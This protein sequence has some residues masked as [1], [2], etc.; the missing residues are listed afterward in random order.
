MENFLALH[1]LKYELQ[2]VEHIVHNVL[3]VF[4]SSPEP[5]AAFIAGFK[6]DL[7]GASAKSKAGIKHDVVSLKKPRDRKVYVEL[8][9]AA[10]I[11]LAIR[12][13]DYAEA[14][15]LIAVRPPLHGTDLLSYLVFQEIEQLLAFLETYFGPYFNLD[16]WIPGDYQRIMCCEIGTGIHS[17]HDG[18][19]SLGAGT[20][21]LAITMLPFA[22]FLEVE[23][24]DT[25]HRQVKNLR[26]LKERLFYLSQ[27]GGNEKIDDSLRGLLHSI[28]FNSADFYDY[29][30]R[31]VSQRVARCKD[32]REEKITVLTAYKRQ[33]HQV[34]P[35]IGFKF[36]IDRLSL[37]DE[38]SAWIQWEIDC[39][40][41][42]RP[43]L[44]EVY[45]ETPSEVDLE[46][47]GRV[48]WDMSSN[49]LAYLIHIF[50][51]VDV[52][53]EKDKKTLIQIIARHFQTNRSEQININS[54][55]K[56]I[57][58]KHVGARRKVI[59]LLARMR[60]YAERDNGEFDEP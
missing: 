53:P 3:P 33:I 4:K 10:L 40:R 8:H 51:E 48:F 44:N 57:S 6:K 55:N 1:K 46:E 2:P 56:K 22:R 52:V 19:R 12:L 30:T 18:L 23:G 37:R 21:L 54:F 34:S 14:T 42:G 9:Q 43:S 45:S 28:N 36:D 17:I 31:E 47:L 11:D 25:S 20:E 5:D 24:K 38:L 27:Q 29:C 49:E 15:I 50:L 58:E 59:D 35:K 41:D 60:N 16:S 32:H 7:H 13:L 26:Y 39:I